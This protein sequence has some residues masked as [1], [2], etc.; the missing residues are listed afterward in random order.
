MINTTQEENSKLED[1]LV[2]ENFVDVFPKELPG[3][4]LD[5]AIL[6]EIELLPRTAP[7]LKA[8]YRIAPTKL[9]EL[10]FQ[11]QELLEKG[12]IRPSHSP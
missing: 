3:L 12:F 4:P 5:R 8:P 10:Q 7:M 1:I 6:F 11:L 2:V 9:K